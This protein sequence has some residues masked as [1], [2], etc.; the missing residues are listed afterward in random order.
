MPL[1][2]KVYPSS[3]LLVVI[4]KSNNLA[5]S[6]LPCIQG[7]DGAW[8]LHTNNLLDLKP[9][10]QIYVGGVIYFGLNCALASISA[11]LPTIIATFGYS[12]TNKLLYI[13]NM[14]TGW[15]CSPRCRSAID[16]APLRGCC[17]RPY[18]LFKGFRFKAVS[19]GIYGHC[20]LD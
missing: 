7:L 11:F 2:T 12:T 4:V 5:R 16:G 20:L 18:Q 19:R 3:P 15:C 8:F 9:G 14:L 13:C 10:R 6:H 17:R 1:S